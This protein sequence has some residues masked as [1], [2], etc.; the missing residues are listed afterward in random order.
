MLINIEK[1]SRKKKDDAKIFIAQEFFG[2]N[3]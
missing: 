2:S 1:N 3:A